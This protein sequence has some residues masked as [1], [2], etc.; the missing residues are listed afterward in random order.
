[1]CSRVIRVVACSVLHF[2][3]LSI[4]SLVYG[5]PTFYLAIHQLRGYLG[6]FYFLAIMNNDFVTDHVLFL[7]IS[8][9]LLDKY[10]GEEFQG[11]IFLS[12]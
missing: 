9:F 7:H 11:L 10:V 5:S 2:F 12:T 8:C 6:C 3:L 4:N 1:M